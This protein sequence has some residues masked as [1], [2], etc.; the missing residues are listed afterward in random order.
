MSA[1]KRAKDCGMSE[2]GAVSSRRSEKI[3]RG[4]IIGLE[5]LPW[6]LCWEWGWLLSGEQRRKI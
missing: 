1:G 6:C 5:E 4:S 2:A 3:S